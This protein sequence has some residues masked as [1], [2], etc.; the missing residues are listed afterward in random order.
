MKLNFLL[1][2][3]CFFY[4]GAHPSSTMP[5]WRNCLS[6]IHQYWVG[7][8]LWMPLM[9]TIQPGVFMSQKALTWSG[10]LF[11]QEKTSQAGFEHRTPTTNPKHTHAL[12]RLAM[13]SRSTFLDWDW[14]CSLWINIDSNIGKSQY[15]FCWSQWNRL[16]TRHVLLYLFCFNLTQF[17]FDV[18]KMKKEL[19][20][21]AAWSN[22]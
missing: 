1:K 12:D 2:L 16:Q 14:N 8:E 17:Y 18:W 7:C 10:G 15:I 3:N 9:V 19:F 5:L 4:I 6:P 13:A 20:G 22:G 11:I 21:E